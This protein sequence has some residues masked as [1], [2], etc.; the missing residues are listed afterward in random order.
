MQ[1]PSEESPGSEIETKVEEDRSD[2]QSEAGKRS[3][4]ITVAYMS[5]HIMSVL[6]SI[7]RILYITPAEIVSQCISLIMQSEMCE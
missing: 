5:S 4:Q 1:N 2:Q 7:S 3:V 6:D